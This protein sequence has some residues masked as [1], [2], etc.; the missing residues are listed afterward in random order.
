MSKM[1]Y[2]RRQQGT[3]R[4]SATFEEFSDEGIR[5]PPPPP[6]PSFDA[7]PADIDSSFT[8]SPSSLAAKAIRASSARRDSSLSSAYRHSNLPSAPPVALPTPTPPVSSKD[9]RVYEYTSMK[10]LN[11]SKQGFWG[12]LARKAKSII[13]DEQATQHSKAPGRVEPQMPG[14]ASTGKVRIS[15]GITQNLKRDNPKLLKGF[16]AITSSLSNI[17]STIGN[18]LEEGFTVVENRTSGIIQE[19]RNHIKKKPG[20]SELERQE[21]NRSA[22]HQHSQSRTQMQTDRELQLK[23]SRDVA[24]AMAAKAK[25]LLRELK[26]VKADLAFAKDRCAQLEEENRILR[27]SRERGDNP[28]DDDMIRLQLET[29]LAEK[30]RLAHENSVFARENRFLREVVEYHQLTMQD[31]VYFDESN[32]EVTEVNPLNLPPGPHMQLDSVS[33]SPTTPSLSSP[34]ALDMDTKSLE[35]RRSVSPI[36]GRDTKTSELTRSISS[37]PVMDTK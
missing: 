3:S 14:A 37:S 24:M 7:L 17:G 35:L 23:A 16:D 28:E 30:A 32:E 15:K 8:S 6:P 21:T 27:E 5:N 26:T 19:T 12:S 4:P 22:T 20:S 34:T 31:V 29:L 18:A 25:L 11:E 13:E 10:T 2:R 36:P 33:S 1:A 9:S